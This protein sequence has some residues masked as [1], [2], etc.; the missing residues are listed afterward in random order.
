MSKERTIGQFCASIL[1]R[2]RRSKKLPDWPP[3]LFAL[4]LGLLK[5]TGAYSTIFQDWPPKGHSLNAWSSG[6][7]RLGRQW[8]SQYRPRQPFQGIESEWQLICSSFDQ[9]LSS[10]P[11]NR[12]LCLAVIKLLATADEASE[13]V[14]MPEDEAGDDL[15]LQAGRKV[16]QDSATLG[17]EIDHNRLRVLPCTHTP[18]NGLTHRSLSLFLSACDGGE[19]RS[20]WLTSQF[21]EHDSLSLLLIPWPPEVLIRDFQDVTAEATSKLPE[22]FGFF[23]YSVPDEDGGLVGHVES[24]YEEAARKMGRIDGVVLPEL[25]VNR[26]QF[27]KLR[28]V[29]P[30]SSFLIAGV[31]QNAT[32]G[33]R[34]T[35][36]VRLSFPPL[37]E[38]VQKKQ[39]PW[40]L[41]DS[42]IIQYGLGGTLSPER[43]WWEYT[44][45]SAR[46]LEFLSVSEDLVI[47]ALVCEDLARPDPVADIVRAVGPNLVIALLMDGPQTKERWAARY[48]TV[49]ADDPGCSVLSLTSLGM[50]RLSRP[51]AGLSRPRVVALWK[52]PINGASEIELP[53]NCDAVAISLSFCHRAEF[54][55]DGRG[56]DI[57]ASTPILAGVHPIEDPRGRRKS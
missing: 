10:L 17:M 3:D 15:F 20:R 14:G 31:G 43:E 42:Q 55:A 56:D 48:A 1:P 27:K 50:A 30:P 53:A 26:E 24:L 5:C 12:P 23:A 22:H 38:V 52:D 8:R 44:D 28:S 13:G 6:A 39:H 57:N 40:K 51:A 47:C 25:A 19:V 45:L 46:T 4:C 21:L 41:T 32:A 9:P 2:L 11:K 34:G 7:A 33:Q 29:L 49:L 35:N 18:Q 54:T 37:Q 36:E 16:L